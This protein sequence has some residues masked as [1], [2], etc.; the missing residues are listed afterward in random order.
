MA[1]IIPMVPIQAIAPKA[2]VTTITFWYTENPTETV[3]LLEKIAAFEA[4]YP[5]IDVQAEGKGFFGVEGDFR[6][7]YLASNDPDVLRSPRDTVIKFANESM[8][9]ALT[10]SFTQADK[11][12][13]LETSLGYMTY[14]GEIWGYPQ[15][16]DSPALFFN[17]YIF[18]EAGIDTTPLNST[19]SWTWAEYDAALTAVNSTTDG[20]YATS[21]AGMFFAGQMYYYGRGAYFFEDNK[22]DMYHAAINNTKS[23]AA[24]TYL[25]DLVTGDLTPPWDQQGWSYFVGDFMAG[26]VA[27]V[28]TGPWEV[29]NLLTLSAQFNGTTHGNDNLGIMLL[30]HDEDGNIGALVGGNYYVV[31]SH[32]TEGAERDAAIALSRWL[33]SPDMMAKSAIEDTH[34]PARKSVM[35]NASVM[36]APN[37]K[38]V[39]VFYEMAKQAV[40]L[41]LSPYYGG[42]EGDFGNKVNEYLSD[43]ITLDEMINE[44]LTLW[45]D[46]LPVGG[47][48]ETTEPAIPGYTA[49]ILIVGFALGVLYLIRKR[50]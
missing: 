29:N 19:K 17:K 34:A 45:A 28:A 21:L 42:L 3:T 47:P 13:F 32:T 48:D 37:F 6:T 43:D 39:Q 16:V 50:K 11:D 46:V 10:D 44:T 26:K 2:A 40:K 36:A 8:I 5:D 23:R 41:T 35:T 20:I 27:M 33:S 7:A 31:S 14:D 30:P 15:A 22:Y 38:T 12:D 4:A 25:H 18:E 9:I 24:L 1:L 49:S